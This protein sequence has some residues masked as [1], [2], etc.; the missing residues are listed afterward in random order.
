MKQR[1]TSGPNSSDMCKHGSLICLSCSLCQ[2]ID[3]AS[4]TATAT[5]AAGKGV[6]TR[7]NLALLRLRCQA[8]LATLHHPP[9]TWSE[10]PEV[11]S[12]F[13]GACTRRRAGVRDVSFGRR[14][15]GNLPDTEISKESGVGRLGS[16]RGR[17]C[18]CHPARPPYVGR[19][20]RRSGPVGRRTSRAEC[21]SKIADFSTVALATASDLLHGEAV[22]RFC[23]GWVT[24]RHRYR[25]FLLLLQPG[26]KLV[27]QHRR[28]RLPSFCTARQMMAHPATCFYN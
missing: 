9:A 10:V 14:Q 28:S 3:G 25:V 26:A 18:C 1:L 23:G 12:R 4:C 20:R 24:V 7:P 5:P 8:P 13:H 19:G 21:L 11:G 6:Q 16:D 22:T 17:N 15:V 2:E 27:I